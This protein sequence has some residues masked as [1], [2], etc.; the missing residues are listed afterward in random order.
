MSIPA[1]LSYDDAVA[2]LEKFVEFPAIFM[3]PSESQSRLVMSARPTWI[4]RNSSH[5]LARVDAVTGKVH[6][7]CHS[8]Q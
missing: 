4:L 7:Q 2:A 3:Q 5:L 1:L 6:A 8:E